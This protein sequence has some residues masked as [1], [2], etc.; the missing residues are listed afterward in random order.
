MILVKIQFFNSDLIFEIIQ[1]FI[2]KEILYKICVESILK[3]YWNKFNLKFI[4]TTSIMKE[5]QDFPLM[6][7][8]QFMIMLHI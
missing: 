8:L 1:E 2:D 6:M 4:S 7:F 3:G 5:I